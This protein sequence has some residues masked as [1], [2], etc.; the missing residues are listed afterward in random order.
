MA[1]ENTEGKKSRF[2]VV[3]VATQTEPRIADNDTGMT[4]DVYAALAKILEDTSI[5]RKSLEQ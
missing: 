4:Y 2:E 5:I 1:K 3:A